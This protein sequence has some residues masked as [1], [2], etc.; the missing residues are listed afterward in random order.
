MIKGIL[1]S[2]AQ[3]AVYTG[4][5]FWFMRHKGYFSKENKIPDSEPLNVLIPGSEADKETPETETEASEAITPDEEADTA[6]K[7]AKKE[8]NSYYTLRQSIVLT[9]V[10][11]VVSF[12]LDI[13]LYKYFMT[14]TE[15]KD[16][17]DYFRGSFVNAL[18][19]AAAITDLKRKKIHNEIILAGII[20]KVI[21]LVLELIFCPHD[22]FIG[23][24]KS[25]GVGFLIGFVML[26]IIG[27]VTRGLGFGDVKLFGIIGVMLGSGGVMVILFASLLLS[28]VVG[29]I[30]IAMRKKTIKSALP[31][32]PFI[33][34]GTVIIEAIGLI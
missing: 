19:C 29:L 12:L 32:A 23:K 4:C 15:Q 17:F 24:L 10:M 1:I 34:I 25:D 9:A 31:M 26:L 14:F 33:W 13:L 30:M 3:A 11:F 28:A 27:V 21:L 16:I 22:V 2:A 5:M 20:A 8:D 6:E 7:T 18:C